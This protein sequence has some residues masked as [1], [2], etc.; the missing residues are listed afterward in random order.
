MKAYDLSGLRKITG[1]NTEFEMKM[2]NMF[3]DQTPNQLKK[4]ESFLE[5]EDYE[6][7][8]MVAHSIK[9]SIDLICRENLKTQVRD[10]ER[11]GK[12]GDKE[13]LLFGLFENL[14]ENLEEVI[15]DLKVDL[16]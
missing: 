6:N 10:L 8:G 16:L 11:I 14:R 4:L 12:E 7:F 2:L 1:G 13:N 15:E 9:P 3:V 5:E